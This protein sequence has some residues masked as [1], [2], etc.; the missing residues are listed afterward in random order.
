MQVEVG[1][2]C[3]HTNFGRRGFSGFGDNIS[4]KFGQISLSDH[5]LDHGRQSMVVKKFN[6]L[7][8]AQN[9]HASRG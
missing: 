6:Q 7:K 4:F 3:M 8:S 9:I 1:V 2:K 5:G